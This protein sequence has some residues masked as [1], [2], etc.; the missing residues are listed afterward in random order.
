MFQLVL[1]FFDMIML[2][3]TWYTADHDVVSLRTCNG[4]F[5]NGV[6]SRGVA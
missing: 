4:Y 5:L 3:E 6:T 1:V 2:S